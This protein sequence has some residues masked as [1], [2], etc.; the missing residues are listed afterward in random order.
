MDKLKSTSSVIKAGSH[1]PSPLPDTA[2]MNANDVNSLHTTSEP[3]ERA[4]RAMELDCLKLLW[5]EELNPYLMAR[6]SK[7]KAARGGSVPSRKPVSTP[8]N[9]ERAMLARAKDPAPKGH[10]KALTGRDAPI[11]SASMNKEW[12][13]AQARDPPT[14]EE[15]HNMAA[16][17]AAG[18]KL[19][20]AIPLF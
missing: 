5:L 7:E 13:G 16:V 19:A 14:F 12:E 17:R 2:P 4:L 9:L 6:K 15:G 18:H 11:W 8:F 20:S 1:V 10:K 3:S